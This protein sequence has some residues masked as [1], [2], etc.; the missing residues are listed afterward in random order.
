SP[1]G[2]GAGVLGANLAQV[3]GQAASAAGPGAFPRAIGASTYAGADTPGG[4]TPL[5]RVPDHLAP[6]GSGP[7]SDPAPPPAPRGAPPGG[8]PPRAAARGAGGGGGGGG[9]TLAQIAD[10]VATAVAEIPLEWED[11]TAVR[12]PHWRHVLSYL[13][14]GGFATVTQDG[15]F[16]EWRMGDTLV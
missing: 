1:T 13:W 6:A 8:R 3:A 7:A 4:T 16:F 9:Y 12:A 2:T 15:D 5:A 10:A 11:L 14:A